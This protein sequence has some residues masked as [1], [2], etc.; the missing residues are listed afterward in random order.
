MNLPTS[1]DP[2]REVPAD[3][4]SRRDRIEAALATLAAEERRIAR[5]GLEWPL[6]RCREQRRYWS[7]LSALYAMR[8][9]LG[10]ARSHQRSR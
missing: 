2:T 4:G 6:A 7:F 3:A 1:A 10:P 5:I 9:D 8:D